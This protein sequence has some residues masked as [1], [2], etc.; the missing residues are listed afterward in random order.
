[1]NHSGDKGL[2][3]GEKFNTLVTC[4]TVIGTEYDDVNDCVYKLYSEETMT[5]PFNL[6][7]KKRGA[8]HYLN[9]NERINTRSGRIKTNKPSICFNPGLLGVT[10]NVKSKDIKKNM[11]KVEFNI[12]QE[13]SKVHH[14]FFSENFLRREF[15]QEGVISGRTKAQNEENQGSS[16]IEEEKQNQ[17]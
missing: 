10:G 16:L 12:K 13:E 15:N 14:P 4:S 9:V 17:E 5:L 11:V 7:M 8:N 1:M 6:I 2:Q 3:L